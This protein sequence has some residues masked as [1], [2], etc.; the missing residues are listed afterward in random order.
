MVLGLIPAIA[1]NIKTKKI[2]TNL[3]SGNQSSEDR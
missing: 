3:Y 1:I 2:I